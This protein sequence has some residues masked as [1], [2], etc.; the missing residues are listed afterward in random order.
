[1]PS[2]SK[3]DAVTVVAPARDAPSSEADPLDIKPRPPVRITAPTWTVGVRS[4]WAPAVIR[5]CAIQ[6]EP[7]AEMRAVLNEVPSRYWSAI[8]SSRAFSVN[9]P[10]S[11]PPILNLAPAR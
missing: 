10:S 5:K 2:L 8:V 11:D 1:M 6:D 7:D 3:N 9:W 4:Y